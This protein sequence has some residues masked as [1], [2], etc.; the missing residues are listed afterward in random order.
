MKQDRAITPVSHGVDAL[1]GRL[2]TE[3]VEAGRVE[4][5]SLKA[6]A[7]RE[8]ERLL[9]AGR[10]EAAQLR[11]AA[12]AEAARLKQGVEEDLRAA[13]GRTV[14]ELRSQLLERFSNDIRRLVA[15]AMEDRSLLHQLILEVAAGA[16]DAAGVAP[17]EPVA[18]LLPAGSND[19]DLR[20]D[21]EALRRSS[22]TQ[23]VLARTGQI[24]TEGVT[25]GVR[26][27]SQAGVVLKLRNGDVE[28]DLSPD[29][30]ASLLLERL[31]PR[32]RAIFDG[33]IR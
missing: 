1:I 16:R 33:V 22:L 17:G 14:L 3:G 10:E 23:L 19:A 21:L 12:R 13:M 29:Q 18:A 5:E 30:V 15:S 11:E 8:A 9:Q 2:R 26:G 25:L 24:L 31:Q 32:F 28:I 20:Q 7:E 27:D 6:E 4:G